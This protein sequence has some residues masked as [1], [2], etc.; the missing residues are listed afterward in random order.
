MLPGWR[1]P[2]NFAPL[3]VSTI[4]T[5]HAPV[6]NTPHT[7]ETAVTTNIPTTL[8]PTIITTMQ[9]GDGSSAEWR[10]LTSAPSAACSNYPFTNTTYFLCDWSGVSSIATVSSSDF[11]YTGTYTTWLPDAAGETT[12]MTGYVYYNN[13]SSDILY[14]THSSTI[15]AATA[16]TQRVRLLGQSGE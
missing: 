11:A 4:S 15:I 10:S 12:T 13:G 7:F 3:F 2:L 1:A 9:I 14:S 16:R 8:T 5:L 6:I